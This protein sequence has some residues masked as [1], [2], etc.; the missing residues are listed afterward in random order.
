[1][2]QAT[3]LYSFICQIDAD[4]FLGF[5]NQTLIKG[6]MPLARIGTLKGS[7]YLMLSQKRLVVS[8]ISLSSHF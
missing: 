3:T 4:K 8:L 1:M 6:D 2:E 5:S 7:P